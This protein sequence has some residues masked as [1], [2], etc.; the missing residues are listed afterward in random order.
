MPRE[1]IEITLSN[2]DPYRSGA[3]LLGIIAY[4]DPRDKNER[5]AF[6]QT[7]VRLAILRRIEVDPDWAKG[8]Q[9][10]RP[11][12][13]TG[14]D[15]LHSSVLRRGTKK[16]NQRLAIAKFLVIPHLRAIDTGKT[17]RQDGYAATVENMSI[18][19][20]NF[21][22]LSSGSAKTVQSRLWKPSK[23]I[24]HAMCAYVIWNEVLWKKWGRKRAR[25][26]R[27]RS[28][29]VRGIGREAPV[30]AS[31]SSAPVDSPNTRTK[32]DGDDL[33]SAPVE[34]IGGEAPVAG[35]PA[36]APADPPNTRTKPD[37]DGLDIPECLNRRH[38]RRQRHLVYQYRIAIGLGTGCA[39]GSDHAAGAAD[40]FDHDRLAHLTDKPPA[41][42]FVAYWTNNGQKA[43]LGLDLSAAIDPTA[44]LAV[45]CGNG[46]MPV[47]APIKVLI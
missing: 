30:A 45:H 23:P 16:L 1:T 20:G 15:V 10:I 41:P 33:G 38:A 39:G 26:K 5:D 47:S 11:A 32:P 3:T 31:P 19:A 13:F 40:V 6:T 34:G 27:D 14:S 8:P 21:L 35:S 4:P 28:A 44:T 12:Y 46:L 17:A 43:A 29:P 42:E 18:L 36:S 25:P 7:L 9:V 24:V 2:L 22:G 37:G